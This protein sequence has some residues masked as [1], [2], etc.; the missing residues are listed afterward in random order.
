M[1]GLARARITISNQSV[2]MNTYVNILE[3]Y[4]RVILMIMK[5][6]FTHL[7]TPLH[8]YT[9]K[10]PK[11][12]QWVESQA[13]GYTLNLFAGETNLN[14]QEYRNDIRENMNADSHMDALEFCDTYEGKKFDTAI[15]DPPYAYRKSMEMYEGAVSSP[16]NQL[17]NSLLKVLT[18]CGRVITFGYHS[19]SMG[20]KRGFYVEEICVMSHGGAI[21]DT[22]ATVEVRYK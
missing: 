16:F 8:K 1:P 9:F 21:H 2:T 17:K 20:E 14:I 19:V 15:L 7:K 5:P 12:K 6:Q 10:A 18:I 4:R 13:D 22:I 11:I 3:K